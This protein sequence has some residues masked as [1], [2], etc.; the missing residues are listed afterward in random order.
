MN[1]NRLGTS[2]SP[3]LR[4]HADNPVDWR[5]WGPEAFAEARERGV[6]VLVSVG[7]ATC[8]W[9]HVMARES[10][11]DPEI[12]ELLRRDFVS[13][14]VDREER[15][16]V[17]ASLMASAS[18]FTQQLGWPLTTFLT[19]DGHVF[20]A[21]TYFP[22][23]PVGQV[24]AFRQILAA[25]LDAWTERRHE[26]DA[27]ASAIAT[28]IRQGA[29]ADATARSG[30]SGAGADPG[31]PSVDT[32]RAVTS[33][34]LQAEDTT[35]GGFGG[36]P[37]FP[38][39]PLLEFLA[40]AAA[41]G[42]AEADGLLDRSLH[43]IRAS[44]LTDA[45][46][47]VFRYA[48]RR[49][50]SVPHYERML[51]D[52]AGLLAVA[53]AEQARG[54]ADFL[55]D[56]LRRADGAFVAAQD[57]E[58]TIDGRRVEGE[59]Y[60]RPIAERAQLDP[61]PLDDQVLTGWNGLA[62]RGLAIAGARHGDPEL[63]A[64]ARGAADAVL[65]AHVQDGHV[66]VRS[67]TPRGVS[68]APATVEDVGLLAE[69]LLELALVT[70]EVSYATVA[71]SL[72]DDGL[73]ERFDVDPVLAAA[74]TATGEQPQTAMRSGTVALASAAATLG[75]LTGDQ[76]LRT[77]AARL[78][79][80]RARTGT[81]RPLGHAD[82]LGVALALQRPSRE[83]VVVTS[84]TDDPMQAVAHRARRPGTVVATT[85]PDQA[86]DWAAAGFS[87]FE[88]RDVLDPAAYVCHDR[89]CDL[90][91]RSADALAGQIV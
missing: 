15:P 34:L 38:S 62:I 88:G 1:D 72:V 54:I 85:T 90:P 52:N 27:N 43:A 64:L 29:V 10:F 35:Y 33:Q 49:D 8:H 23:T 70:G 11:A 55:R 91:S 68:S 63:V 78:V 80:D 65:A 69:G 25:V 73:A 45:D 32:V 89:V 50:W 13:V 39:T 7:Y 56:T 6:P 3:Y 31:L 22:P 16:D 76:E 44:E 57:S 36:A 77:A 67:S 19:P 81:E 18:A 53:G 47:G 30:E 41:D 75:A 2:V 4:L 83:I 79:A 9:C 37:K 28:A 14:K 24:P 12:G 87:L 42:D 84:S 74:G 5:E 82:A 51:S 66:S 26:V 61:P 46:G 58:S 40:D 48:T 21:G 20:F 17:D 59:W 60:R 71:R 86:R